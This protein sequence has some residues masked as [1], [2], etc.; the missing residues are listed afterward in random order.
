M[1][2]DSIAEAL[3]MPKEVVK[4]VLTGEISDE[5]INQYNPAKPPEIRVV[6]R[7]KF[8]RSKVIGF[9]ST[10]G[11][12]AST[13][14]A[15][16]SLSLKGHSVLAV[17]LNEYGHLSNLLGKKKRELTPTVLGWARGSDID[18]IITPSVN[19]DLILG[20]S[21]IKEYLAS[22]PNKMASL[23]HEA[24]KRYEYLIVDCPGIPYLWEEVFQE[25]DLIIWVNKTDPACLHNLQHLENLISPFK[26]KTMVL[27][28]MAQKGRHRAIPHKMGLSTVAD[29]P[30]FKKD[31]LTNTERCIKSLVEI[32]AGKQVRG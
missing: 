3:G 6:E 18:F 22:I 25:L 24:S 21:D 10:G 32:I 11:C 20:V 26:N 31:I 9:V 17:D 30:Y 15:A 2:E 19:Y 1:D 7:K 13:M 23:I 28:N 29:I 14:A 5:I 8:H 4:G 27:F 12:G 16:L